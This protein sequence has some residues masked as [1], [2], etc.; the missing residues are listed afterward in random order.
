[1]GSTR[2]LRIVAI[3]GVVVSGLAVAGSAAASAKPSTTERHCVV[4]VTGVRD[5]VFVTRPEVC[6]ASQTEAVVHAASIGADTAEGERS[7]QVSVTNSALYV[8]HRSVGRV[9]RS[10]GADTIGVHFTSSWFSGSSVR[11]VGT[12]CAGGVWYPTGAW[13]NNIESSLHY[14]GSSPTT[15]YDSS[16][17]SGS[18]YAVHSE[19]NSLGQMN[20]R[21]SCVRYG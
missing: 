11:I 15:F 14:C 19:A 7:R 9:T 6:F 10:S 4:E 16:S 12:T 1:M 5:G 17:C 8:R 2:V 13:N 18:S 21:A 20:N 3:M